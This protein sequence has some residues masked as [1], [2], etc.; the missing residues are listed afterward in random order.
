MRL[1]TLGESMDTRISPKC[2]VSFQLA[3]RGKPLYTPHLRFVL[4]PYQLAWQEP[5]FFELEHAQSPP[6]LKF[7]PVDCFW[8]P[9]GRNL[10][11]LGKI[12]ANFKTYSPVR[13]AHKGSGKTGG[14]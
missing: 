14:V 11:V 6:L 9:T 5:K 2:G 10:R 12:R 1:W 7:R 4:A 8:Q 13:Q 3:V